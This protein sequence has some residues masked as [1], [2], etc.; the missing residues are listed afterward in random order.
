MLVKIAFLQW[1]VE[2]KVRP[3]K[4]KEKDIEFWQAR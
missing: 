1:K 2:G 3:E 4:M